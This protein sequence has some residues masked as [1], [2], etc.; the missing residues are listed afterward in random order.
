M[1]TGVRKLVM[2]S[3][4]LLRCLLLDIR[5]RSHASSLRSTANLNVSLARSAA[6]AIMGRVLV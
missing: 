3:I 5:A 6:K 1:E 2:S 4:A